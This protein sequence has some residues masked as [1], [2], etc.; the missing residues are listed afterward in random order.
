[1]EIK[2]DREKALA[3]KAEA[4]RMAEQEN[5]QTARKNKMLVVFGI[6]MGIPTFALFLV[7]AWLLG[8]WQS[9]EGG[10]WHLLFALGVVFGGCAVA[11][12]GAVLS[13]HWGHAV[14]PSYG[15]DVEYLL[16][17]DGKNILEFSA[18][19]EMQGFITLRAVLENSEHEVE[20]CSICS[21]KIVC[22]TELPE[23]SKPIADL[24]AGKYFVP[25][26]KKV[27]L[28]DVF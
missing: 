22:T 21:L 20:E 5:K 24:E 14:A 15:R 18:K 7:G 6:A 1:M 28:D 23:G 25:Y 2:Y 9:V 19:E 17:T 10:Q 16:A 13:Y 3:R 12:E 4:E 26:Q 8:T 27:N 11:I